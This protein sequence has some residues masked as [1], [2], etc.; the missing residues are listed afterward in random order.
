M[1][2][3]DDALCIIYEL[4]LGLEYMFRL[5]VE[6]LHFFSFLLHLKT[7]SFYWEGWFQLPTSLFSCYCTSWI[8]EQTL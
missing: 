1:D 8:K 7:C 6:S 2:V 3:V 5:F 4:C